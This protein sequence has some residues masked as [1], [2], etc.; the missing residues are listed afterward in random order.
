MIPRSTD[1]SL[2]LKSLATLV[3]ILIAII[4]GTIK[5]TA[6]IMEINARLDNAVLNKQAFD[7]AISKAYD[8]IADLSTRRDS[9]DRDI[10]A[11]QTQLDSLEATR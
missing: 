5:V 7:E 3:G 9:T 4:S 6:H 11:L 8:M 10:I 2:D 1:G